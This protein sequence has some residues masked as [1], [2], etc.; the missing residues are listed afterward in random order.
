MGRASYRDAVDRA[1]ILS[2]LSEFDPHIAGTPPL[3]LDVPTSDIDILCHAPDPCRFAAAVWKAFGSRPDFRMWQWIGADRPV[4]ATF[5]AHE[6]QFEIF[7][8]A[9]PVAEQ[10]GWRHLV[11]ERRL[12]ALGGE[13]LA[14]AVMAFRRNGLKTEPAF[15]AAL[16]LGGDPYQV[17]L[18]MGDWT[19]ESLSASIGRAIA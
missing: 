15:A 17:L 19:D 2:V 18:D 3:D 4:L 14:S 12:L 10:A 8:Q 6:W 11:I 16:K 7:G 9:T 5:E 1:A 13:R